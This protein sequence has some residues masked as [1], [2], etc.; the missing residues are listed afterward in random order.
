MMQV[1]LRLLPCNKSENWLNNLSS[2][3]WSWRVASFEL[4]LLSNWA[5]CDRLHPFDHRGKATQ[6]SDAI[7]TA[8]QRLP[9]RRVL[10]PFRTR[11]SQASAR[12]AAPEVV[13]WIQEPE[14]TGGTSDTA[15]DGQSQPS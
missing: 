12:H 13:L 7:V 3:R 15:G 11:A 2:G 10:Y 5:A 8:D 14:H 6:V 1:V 9:S 4:A